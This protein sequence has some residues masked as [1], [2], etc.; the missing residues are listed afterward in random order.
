MAN[1]SKH[2]PGPW[3]DSPKAS[4][5]IV[6]PN[7]QPGYGHEINDYGGVL[8]AESIASC[9]K[10]IIRRA[11]SMLALLEKA[12]PIIEEEAERRG[13]VSPDQSAK[14]YSYWSE[15]RELSHEIAV[16]IDK[17]YGREPLPNDDPDGEDFDDLAKAE[18]KEA[19][20]E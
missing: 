10:P 7:A 6:A 13:S 5:A 16:E 12:L 14:A 3:I 19:Q 9:N 4:D 11:P 17:A 2:F 15:M 18:G 20:D 8:V 1:E